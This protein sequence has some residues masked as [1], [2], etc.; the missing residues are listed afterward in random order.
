MDMNYLLLLQN[1]RE[2]LHG[3]PD[4]L[5]VLISKLGETTALILVVA[6]IYYAIDKELG[7]YIG[8]NS[9]I[10]MTLNG[11]LKITACV[12]RPWI[13]DPRI[14]P[15]AG[16][17]AGA[18][19][20]SFP[21]GHSTIATAVYGGLALK[22][23]KKRWLSAIFAAVWLLLCFSRNYLGVHTPQDVIV[24]I[25]IGM[26]LLW[27]T[28]FMETKLKDHPEWDV[29]IAAVLLVVGVFLIFYAHFKSYPMD[30]GADGLLLADPEVMKKDSCSAAGACIGFAFGWLLE[31]R[32]VNF[33][34]DGG[35]MRRIL[36]VIF[37]IITILAVKVVFGKIFGAFLPNDFAH[38]FSMCFVM[39]WTVALY[40]LLV[41]KVEAKT[42]KA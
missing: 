38:V 15:V 39:I 35:I 10:G 8:F 27:L 3:A 9:L 17:L 34:V 26:G 40:P 11:I 20:Y 4:G 5:F 30:I 22:T 41:R 42:V 21:S 31:R 33:T 32:Y 16:A 25:L 19:G 18:T 13:R 23:R 14:H 28:A 1:M 37:G 12:Y 7:T 36:R 24:A 29:R 2:A 6:V